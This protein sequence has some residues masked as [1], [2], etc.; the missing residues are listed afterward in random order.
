MENVKLKEEMTKTEILKSITLEDVG[1]TEAHKFDEIKKVLGSAIDDGHDAFH[2]NFI[3]AAFPHDYF[4]VSNKE[5]NDWLGSADALCLKIVE[6]TDEFDA[7]GLYYIENTN[8]AATRYIH[9]VAQLIHE[10]LVEEL[11]AIN[12][13]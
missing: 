4:F 7:L 3:Y 9:V 11:D 2:H 1:L 13:N 12:C 5:A 8:Y 6:Q 10:R